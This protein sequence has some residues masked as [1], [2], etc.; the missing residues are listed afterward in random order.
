MILTTIPNH[1]TSKNP[2]LPFNKTYWSARLVISSVS[3]HPFISS[4]P[5][6]LLFAGLLLLFLA[7]KRGKSGC[8]GAASFNLSI[9]FIAALM[10]DFS[11]MVSVDINSWSTVAVLSHQ[12][13]SFLV[14]V[15]FGFALGWS[16]IQP[17]SKTAL[18]IYILCVIVMLAS[19][20]SGYQL[21]FS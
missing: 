19:V 6:A 17:F 15:L 14:T 12:G 9:G 10:A 2:K 18:L 13:Y 8:T 21:V 4:F 3:F 1:Q 16:Y 20:F 5:T 11:G 7:Y